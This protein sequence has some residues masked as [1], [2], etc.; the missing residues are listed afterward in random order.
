[1][2]EIYASLRKPF[3]AMPRQVF[4]PVWFFMFFIMIIVAMK[5]YLLGWR[6]T[7]AIRI[8]MLVFLLHAVCDAFFLDLFFGKQQRGLATL[9]VWLALILLTLSV[10]LFF[11]IDPIAGFLLLLPLVWLAYLEVLSTSVW[12]LNRG[13][14]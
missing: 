4:R 10:Y 8:A 11:L 14:S 13:H 12:F 7:P 5:V 6:E 1:M 9:D 3:F 2:R